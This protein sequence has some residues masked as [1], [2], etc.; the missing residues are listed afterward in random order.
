MPAILA[1]SSVSSL[2]QREDGSIDAS[3]ETGID[4]AGQGDKA[5][6]SVE[7]MNKSTSPVT[8]DLEL[9]EIRWPRLIGFCPE[10]RN[11]EQ[12]CAKQT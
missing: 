6:R 9:Q 7:Q 12:D 10:K 4:Q 8:C 1:E 11:Y 3:Y 5:V 2:A